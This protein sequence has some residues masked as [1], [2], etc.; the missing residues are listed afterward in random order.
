MKLAIASDCHIE[1]GNIELKNT[2][3]AEVL[4][5]AGDI[6]VAHDLDLNNSEFSSNK[7]KRIQE[8]FVKVCREFSH[9]VYV[10]GNHEHY[11]GDFKYTVQHLKECLGYLKNLHILDTETFKYKDV[12]FIGGT[13][14]TDM[15]KEDQLTVFTVRQRM[16]DYQV[17]VNSDRMT[18]R[19]VPLYKENPLF[20]PD[21][22][23]GGRYE[24]DENGYCTKIGE[25]IK[26]EPSRL[27]PLDTVDYHRNMVEFINIVTSQKHSEKFVV[28]GHHA[29]SE[30]SVHPRF[31][32]FDLMNGAYR[33]DLS[34]FI[35]DRPQVKLW[36]HG[37]MHDQSDYMIGSTRV[38]CNPRGYIG[39]EKCADDFKLK[40][41]EV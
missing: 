19:K 15:N 4:V 30:M 34:E 18:Q 21:G 41:L 31:K 32:H 39:H 10:V 16:S 36:I 24:V 7:S 1:F 26:E 40:Y 5:L 2:E 27:D 23:N 6:C 22:R 12:T 28:V 3:N 37:H 33:S 13:L 38:V 25:K 8:F 14:W 11:H 35:L 9:V 20:T 17:T 29:P